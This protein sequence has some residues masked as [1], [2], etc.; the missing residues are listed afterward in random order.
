MS[1]NDR[2]NS[3]FFPSGLDSVDAVLKK[4]FC[5]PLKHDWLFLVSLHVLPEGFIN[6]FNQD[7]L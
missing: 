7:C 4:P 1:A 3:L 6:I 5:V 2:L